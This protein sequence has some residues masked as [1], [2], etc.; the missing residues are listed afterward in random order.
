MFKSDDASAEGLHLVP[1]DRY[2][3]TESIE[4]RTMVLWD[5]GV[6]GAKDA[7]PTQVAKVVLEGFPLLVKVSSWEGSMRLGIVCAA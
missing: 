6:S 3:V 4:Q 7:Q 1:G 2:L 5:L